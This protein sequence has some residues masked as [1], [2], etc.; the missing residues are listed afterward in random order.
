MIHPIGFSQRVALILLLA[1][2]L[3]LEGCI[4]ETSGVN[5]GDINLMPLDQEWQL[6]SELAKEI[7]Q[8]AQMADSPFLQE[9]VSEMG[10]ELA[11]QTELADREW[12]FHV[13]VDS[14]VNA[15]NI[16]GG[17]VFV[18]TGLIRAAERPSEL[19]GVMAHEVAHGVARHGTERM[20]KAYGINLIAQLVLGQ[21]VGLLE[22]I[23]AQLIGAGTM[24][25]FSRDD[26]READDLGLDF[27]AD[28]GYDPM[29]M[30]RMFETLLE[31]R[32]RRPNA[33]EQFFAT[34][35]LTE[36]RIQA[37]AEEAQ[38]LP[39]GSEEDVLAFE[40]AQELAAR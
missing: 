6:G 18:N 38:A 17:H 14:S 34:H 10:Q 26:E 8:Q 40:R 11:A 28:A 3:L 29:G 35:P 13:I 36:E 5:R 33:I 22:Q 25:K 9:Y 4:C 39:A 19:A 21:D 7:Q 30:P 15:F 27:L 20:T 24:A 2:G 23:A 31:I 12:T 32:Q 1:A 37:A 16:P